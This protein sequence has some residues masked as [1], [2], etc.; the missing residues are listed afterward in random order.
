MKPNPRWPA[1]V[2]ACLSIF[3]FIIIISSCKKNKNSGIVEIDGAGNEKVVNVD[4]LPGN[5]TV[6]VITIK[7]TG[8]GNVHVKLAIDTAVSSSGAKALR[9]A[10]YLIGNLEF[11]IPANNSK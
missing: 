11:D 2:S 4:F 6:D 7:N 9:A 5:Q 1:A 8:S 10:N 3:L